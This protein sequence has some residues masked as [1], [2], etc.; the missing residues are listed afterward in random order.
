MV[1]ST[2]VPDAQHSNHI[3]SPTLGFLGHTFG[4]P[5]PISGSYSPGPAHKK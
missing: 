1:L 3:V 4:N 5:L 2:Y